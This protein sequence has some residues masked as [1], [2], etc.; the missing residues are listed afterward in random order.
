[1]N[2]T[3]LPS[4]TSLRCVAALLVFF[5]HADELIVAQAVAL[6]TGVLDEQPH[7]WFDRV[8]DQGGSGVA[9]FFVLSGF[10]LAWSRS[11]GTTT[12]VFYR[13]RFA[14]IYPAYAAT[15]L[16]AVPIIF[17]IGEIDSVLHLVQ[18]FLPLTLLQAW[19]PHPRIVYSGNGVAW[20]LSCE[21]FFYAMFPFIVPRL[22]AAPRR[23]LVAVAAAGAL[24]TLVPAA[25][26]NP[27]DPEGV[28][29]LVIHTNPV[30]RMGEFVSGIALALLLRS[31]VRAPW[32]RVGPVAAVC[33]AAYLAMGWAPV[34]MRTPLMVA[35]FAALVFAAAQADVDGTTPT[36]L[37]HR[38]FVR[39]GQ[40]SF[41][42][43]LV[44][45]LVLRITRTG[46]FEGWAAVIATVASLAVS[47]ALAGVIFHHLEQ[48]MERRLRPAGP[49]VV[50]SPPS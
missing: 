12:D 14:R 21:A 24:V 6:S 23:V 8:A 42:F 13:R 19:L 47:T 45:Q 30:M 43:Y 7:T 36:V 39:L 10:V 31:G 1:M 48:P 46:R 2:R 40:W 22:A 5:L 3:H 9:F 11:P 25:I 33:A 28:A 34:G 27:T 29:Y 15:C 4:L 37:H 49:S 18:A 41:A 17:L 32:L 20:S 16:A 38:W 50:P 35:P 26:V 44:H